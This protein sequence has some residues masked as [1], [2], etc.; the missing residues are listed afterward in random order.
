MPAASPSPASSRGD[1]VAAAC[2]PTR[3]PL[4]ADRYIGLGP[5]HPLAAR[6]RL[7]LRPRPAA[8]SHGAVLAV[9]ADARRKH[10]RL[11]GAQHLGGQPVEPDVSRPVAGGP[12][13]KW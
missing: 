11:D 13:A 5:A 1:F 2:A 7:R 10:T 6:P 8:A 4:S 12:V 9:P 3:R